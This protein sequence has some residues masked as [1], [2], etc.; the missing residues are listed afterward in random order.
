MATIDLV[1][2]KLNGDN[3]GGGKPA[4]LESLFVSENGVYVPSE[5]V[6]GY[7]QVNVN[8]TTPTEVFV[9]PNGIKFGYSTF[10]EIPSNLDFSKVTNM[11]NM[12][13][14]CA[15]LT[16][17]P[18]IDTSKVTNMR[19]MFYYCSNLTSIPLLD[20]SN[21]T[22]M[23]SVFSNCSKLTTIPQ[24]DTSSV[25]QMERMFYGC[26]KLQSIPLL[27][28]GNVTN[29]SNIFGY[30]NITTLTD[31]GGFK[32]LKIN[33]ND[34]YG[35]SKIPNLTYESVMNVINNLYDFRGNGDTTTTR[36]IQFNANSIALLSDADIAIATNKGWVIS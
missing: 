26:S 19:A 29:I 8:V 11:H 24:L 7:N 20:T 4:T 13:N 30:Y 21:V 1:K 28:C 2:I 17:I 27:E 22:N 35:L 5:G 31:L 16:T 34:N 14:N 32:N 25:T 23:D 36:T 33:C 15:N 9:V 3:G 12:F 18:A 10:T 6:D